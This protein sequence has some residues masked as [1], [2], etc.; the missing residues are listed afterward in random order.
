MKNY[1]C[2]LTVLMMSCLPEVFSQNVKPEPSPGG[3]KPVI[4]K[5]ETTKAV[6]TKRPEPKIPDECP[7]GESRVRVRMLL[8]ETGKVTGVEVA[9]KSI[10]DAFD[11]SAVKAA[12]KIKFTPAREGGVAVSK[13]V[14]IEYSYNRS[15]SFH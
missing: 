4:V 12:R 6:I 11:K 13:Y 10:C 9:E 1:I 15:T 2:I 5:D 3:A 8:H 7:E 14:T